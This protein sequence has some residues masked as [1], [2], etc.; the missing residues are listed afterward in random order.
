MEDVSPIP[1]GRNVLLLL[2]CTLGG[3]HYLLFSFPRLY[4]CTATAPKAIYIL[5]RAWGMEASEVAIPPV[6]T[7]LLSDGKNGNP[8]SHPTGHKVFLCCQELL[9]HAASC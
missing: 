7:I 6:T 2:T 1:T 5:T 4:W 8:E 9:L 3:Y